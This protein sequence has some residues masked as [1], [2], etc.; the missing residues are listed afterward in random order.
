MLKHIKK[1]LEHNILRL[2]IIA[3]L[4]IAFLS[5][6]AIP[7]INLGLE[8]KSS[9]KILHILAYFTLSS[10]WFL[11]FQKKMGNLFF[12][13]TLI[14]FLI[15]YGIILEALQGGITTYRT[16]DVY[17]VVANTIGVLLALLLSGRFMSW[18]K[19]F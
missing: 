9:D 19:A 2:A 13:I 7:K 6:T 15:F 1:L 17:D 18:F 3:T 4:I 10:V 16:G 5:L 14:I 11:A 12:K 8:I